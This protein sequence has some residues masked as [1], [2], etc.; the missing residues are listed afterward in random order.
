[1]NNVETF[2][3]LSDE[4][5]HF[6]TRLYENG[7]AFMNRR[8]FN[9]YHSVHKML[10]YE[11]IINNLSLDQFPILTLVHVW[12]D[13]VPHP[14]SY[15]PFNFGDV[16]KHIQT[17]ATSKFCH[18]LVTSGHEGIKT[19]FVDSCDHLFVGPYS[20]TFLHHYYSLRLHLLLLSLSSSIPMVRTPRS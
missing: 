1:M 3:N 5:F 16:E 18:Q 6:G 4:I 11:Y 14:Q 13:V 12:F 20:V 9:Y 2:R 7:G 19:S 8:S 15:A 17:I 10:E